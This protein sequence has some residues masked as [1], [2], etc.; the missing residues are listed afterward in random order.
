MVAVGGGRVPSSCCE[1][2]RIVFYY[3]H[4]RILK[5]LFWTVKSELSSGRR[6]FS[7]PTRE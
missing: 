1:Y 2:C 6:C 3:E 7:F 4:V 5:I